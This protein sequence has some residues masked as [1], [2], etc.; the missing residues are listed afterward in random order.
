M[1]TRNKIA[2]GLLAGA[3]LAWGTRA[4]LRNRRRIDLDGRVVIVTGGSTGHGLL[5]AKIAARR[6]AR[7]AIAARDPGELNAAEDELHRLGARDVLAIPTDVRDRDQAERLIATVLER[8][9]KVDVLINNAGIISV[10][11]I[12]AMTVED[13]QEAVATNFWGAVYTSLAVLPHMRERRSGRIA[14][15]GS[16]GSI[17]AV[18][19]MAPYTA[20]K[21]ALAGFTGSLRAELAKDNIFVT[22]VYPITMRTGGHAH[23]WFKGDPEAEYTWFGLS[24]TIP[25]LSVSAEGVAHRLWDGVLH[26]DAEVMAWPT[27]LAAVSHALFPNA[28]DEFLAALN[29]ALPSPGEGRPGPVQG[30]DLRGTVPD[31]LNRAIPEGT[32]PG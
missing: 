18:P 21:F 22:G 9:G 17:V 25:G 3:G 31:Y 15:V 19:H 14:N 6:G 13:F 29:L 24:D 26:G 20:S 11:P 32:R 16:V 5:V 27:R 10:G 8:W 30:E 28:M 1:R 7:V 12:E 2:L 4:W 23:A